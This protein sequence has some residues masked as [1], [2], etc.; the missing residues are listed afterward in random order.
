[1]YKDECAVKNY[2]YIFCNY[3]EIFNKGQLDKS[4][5]LALLFGLA[6]DHKKFSISI[7]LCVKGYISKSVEAIQKVFN[8]NLKTEVFAIYKHY[9]LLTCIYNYS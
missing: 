1:M 3:F 7:V 9:F 4:L 6:N 8:N 5:E 2:V